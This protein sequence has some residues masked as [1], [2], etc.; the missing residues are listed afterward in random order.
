MEAI[1]ATLFWVPTTCPFKAPAEAQAQAKV[2]VDR[3]A[4]VYGV[5]VGDYGPLPRDRVRVLL[6][7]RQVLVVR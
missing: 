4:Q 5:D 7:N 3:V 1:I 6:Y 2:F